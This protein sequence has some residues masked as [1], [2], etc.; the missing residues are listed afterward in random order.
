M[1]FKKLSLLLSKTIRMLNLKISSVV[2]VGVLIF[3]S[4]GDPAPETKTTVQTKLKPIEISEDDIFQ[5]NKILA[6][7][8]NEE[9][10][11]KE[12]NN[13]FLKGLNAFRN[14][15]NLD[16]A[17]YYLRQSILKEPTAKAYFELGN[18]YMDKKKYDEALISYGLAEQLNYEPFS[19]ILY[20]KACLYSLKE[21][22]ELAGKY[23]EYSIQAGYNNIDH[24]QKDKDLD[25]LRNTYYFKQAL[26]KGMRG[27]SDAENLF[28]LQ[29]K[30]Q[31][32]K[33]QFPI[34]L[35]SNLEWEEL[36]PLGTISYEYEKYI[37]EM[38]DEEFSRE[39][40]KMFYYYLQPYETEN[41]VALV[42]I[43]R[44]EYMGDLAPL[45]YRLA[46]FTH[47][48]KLI[49]KKEISGRT[50][51]GEEIKEGKLLKGGKIEVS[52][53]T[54]VYE[55]D[56]DEVGYYDNPIVKKNFID[57]KVLTISK[58]GKITESSKK[59]V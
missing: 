37:A 55:K 56:P 49:D 15:R 26:K 51:L 53:Y 21:E 36:E 30:K 42:Y 7:L 35:K 8:K 32:T 43:V 57:K 41:Y 40:S 33:A 22:T 4:C 38:R 14:E 11:I 19:K 27:M 20:N 10:F 18:V 52:R 46:T 34:S 50:S 48:G 45:T 39:V 58:D 59:A 13:F 17:D 25:E 23:L 5:G 29:F 1:N 31:F 3:S 12:S 24:I 47:E 28:W 16:S 9:K 2:I 6:F 44:D 54:P